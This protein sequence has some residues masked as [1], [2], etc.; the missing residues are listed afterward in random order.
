MF[1]KVTF[2]TNVVKNK[3]TFESF[4]LLITMHII[5]VINFNLDNFNF[6]SSFITL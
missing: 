2:Y 6:F 5:N 4:N 1:N 3:V